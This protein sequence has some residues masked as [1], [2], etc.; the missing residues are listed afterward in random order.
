MNSWIPKNKMIRFA[1]IAA[2]MSVILYFAGL[3]IVFGEIKKIENF[4]RDTE[5]EVYKKEKLLAVRSIAESNKEPIQILK[6]FFIQKGDEVKF[7][8]QIEQTAR[9]SGIKFEIT[10][11]DLKTDGSPSPYKEDV[12]VKMNMEG[13]W[14]NIM[15]FINKLEKM[16]FG[17]SVQK[18]NLNTNIPNTWLGFIE[19]IIFREK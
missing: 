4:Y 8:E 14:K 11:I 10:S 7:I 18:L 1:A 9:S 15:H 2:L 6:D 3:F 17:I 13:S 12:L 16:N 19:F 5:S